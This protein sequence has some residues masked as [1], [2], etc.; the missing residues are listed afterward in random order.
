MNSTNDEITISAVGSW[1]HL[2]DENL[3]SS[4]T[5]LKFDVWSHYWDT[6]DLSA[7]TRRV[8]ING[9]EVDHKAT[10]SGRKLES[11]GVLVQD[12]DSLCGTFQ[13]SQA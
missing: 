9:G 3:A 4:E 13:A 2:F 8:Y 12:Q 7:A 5:N 1:S 6:W 11:G 10:T